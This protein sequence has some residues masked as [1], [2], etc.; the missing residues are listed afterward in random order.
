MLA[1]IEFREFVKTKSA[2]FAKIIV[3]ANVKIEQ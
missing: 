2:Q 3:D 1:A